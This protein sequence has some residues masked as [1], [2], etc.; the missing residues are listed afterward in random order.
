MIGRDG[1]K[2][3][4]EEMR[5]DPVAQFLHGENGFVAAVARNEILGLQLPPARGREL[6]L[7]VRQPLVPRAGKALLVGARFGGV[8]F[9]GVKF[10]CGQCGAEKLV[11]PLIFIAGREFSLDPHLRGAVILPVGEQAHAVAGAEDFVEMIAQ[12]FEGEIAVDRLRDLVGRLQVERNARDN[13]ER[14]QTDNGAEKAVAVF[15]ARQMHDFSIS[16][17][18][19]EARDGR[20]QVAVVQSRPVRCRGDG[21]GDGDVRQRR[22]VVQRPS[23]RV[24][25]WRQ[26]PVGDARAHRCSASLVVD[27]DRVEALER[28]QVGIAVGDGVKRVA[29]ALRAKSHAALYHLAHLVD[30]AGIVHMIRAERDVA[31]PVFEPF[32][33]LLAMRGPRHHASGHH[34]SCRLQKLALVH[35]RLIA[36]FAGVPPPW[37]VFILYAK[38]GTEIQPD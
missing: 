37:R 14:A 17:D 4:D 34:R 27:F 2:F 21:A 30:R 29:R 35:L 9:D 13:S 10:L 23:A 26:L 20:G 6:E 31:G 24:D 19:L 3:G 12:P 25:R 32:A 16:R 38:S 15:F 11:R 8:A 28:D 7:E 18:D 1:A 22:Q 33:R 5:R 36:S